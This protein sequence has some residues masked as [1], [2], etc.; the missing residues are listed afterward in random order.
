MASSPKII[1]IKKLETPSN[2]ILIITNNIHTITILFLP[3]VQ[4]TYI[5]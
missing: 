4:V 1:E 2:N 3:S 5:Q